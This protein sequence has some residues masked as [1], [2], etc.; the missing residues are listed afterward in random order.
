MSLRKIYRGVEEQIQEAI[1]K[2]DF[3]N[4]PG[5]GKPLNLSGWQKTPPHLRMGYS[6]LK[7]AGLVPVEIQARKEIVE[8]RQ[9]LAETEDKEE[10]M[11][12]TNRLN[13]L[14]TTAAIKAASHRSSS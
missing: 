10:R 8:I 4:L 3:D 7:S 1:A 2:G 6:M 14:T 5:K 12:L 13:S 9:K 11:R